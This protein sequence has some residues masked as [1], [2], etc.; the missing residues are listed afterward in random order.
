MDQQS[1]N[2]CQFRMR[3]QYSHEATNH[4]LTLLPAASQDWTYKKLEVLI[5][6]PDIL[7]LTAL[8]STGP[9]SGELLQPDDVSAT[10]S[11]QSATAPS[12][13]LS[14]AAAAAT[15]PD[16]ALVESLVEL[17]FGENLCKRAAIATKNGSLE[18]SATWVL[19]HMEDP[20]VDD[21]LPG[22]SDRS[23]YGCTDGGA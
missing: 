21:P 1:D 20:G 17:G 11:A 23:T 6:V 8:R 4:W 10:A 2:A 15:T 18:E 16:P 5:E 3:H 13:A 19:T 7:D 12:T 22:E 14:A 9:E